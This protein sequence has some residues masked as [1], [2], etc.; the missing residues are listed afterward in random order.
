MHSPTMT[1]TAS[2][3]LAC[4]LS[5]PAFAGVFNVTN[6]NPSGPGSLQQAIDLSNEGL[7]PSQIFFEVSGTIPLET[8]LP[9]ILSP[10][11][12]NGGQQITLDGQGSTRI[13]RV[14]A[15]ANLSGSSFSGALT[16]NGLTVQNAYVEPSSNALDRNPLTSGGGVFLERGTLNVANS[17]FFENVA[18]NGAAI[19]ALGG[20]GNQLNIGNTSFSGNGA[21]NGWGGA[22]YVDADQ[23]WDPDGVK[24]AIDNST[25]TNNLGRLGGGFAVRENNRG[26]SMFSVT[27][28]EFTGNNASG[29]GVAYNRETTLLIDGVTMTD[30]DADSSNAGGAFYFS[31]FSD[32]TIR[33]S[34]IT[35]SDAGFGG[36]MAIFGGSQITIEDSTITGNTAQ[37]TDVA[38]GDGGDGGGIYIIQ[39]F[40][41]DSG[42]PTLRL[43]R[44]TV[45]DNHAVNGFGGGINAAEAIVEVIESLIANNTVGGGGGGIYVDRE[46]SR[47][48]MQN[49]TV[50]GNST[51]G[52]LDL[53]PGLSEAGRGGGIYLITGKA[54]IESSTIADNSA[55][56]RGGGLLLGGD[57]NP[58]GLSTLLNTILAGNSALFGPNVESSEAVLDS[59]GYN[60][61]DDSGEGLFDELTDLLNAIADLQPLA[62][63]GGPTLTQALGIETA[64]IDNG[65]TSLPTD[66]RGFDRPFGL[67]PDIG[68]FEV[69]EP[70]TLALVGL[71][72][73]LFASRFRAVGQ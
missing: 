49:S 26:D 11:T 6:L 20:E 53:V 58:D 51:T 3:L 68:A 33:N 16:L 18:G 25:F 24:V 41:R 60:L 21:E 50:T 69:P 57:P 47:L 54:T 55:T 38:R 66:Q 52:L 14:G 48:L 34:S 40:N 15:D 9:R 17:N 4:G 1:R 23:S 35:D 70:S 5:A 73:I 8:E 59:L 42:P 7:D 30:N 31:N 61:L 56:E 29:G 13:F 36:A 43:V 22:I 65:F 19:Y 67:A 64:A 37:R 10:I 27:N 72:A 2:L 32:A 44:S 62:D 39:G 12:I 63:N 71:G 46:S 45:A 28:S